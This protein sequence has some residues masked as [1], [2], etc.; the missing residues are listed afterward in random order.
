MSSRIDLT[1]A[2]LDRLEDALEDLELESVPS[3]LAADDPVA[4]RFSEYRELVLLAREAMPLEDVPAGLLDGVIAEAHQAAAAAPVAAAASPSFWSRWRLGTWVPAL[5]FAGSAA[6]L[7]VM[8][9]PRGSEPAGAEVA[10][11]PHG[12]GSKESSK[13]DAK[14]DAS[15][16]DRQLAFAEP[17]RQEEGSFGEREQRAGGLAIGERAP[18]AAPPPLAEPSAAAEAPTDDEAKATEDPLRRKSGTGGKDSPTSEP[19]PAP[20]APASAGGSKGKSEPRPDPLGGVDTGNRDQGED[21]KKADAS[22]LR[23]EIARADADRRGGSCGLAKM[24]YDKLRKADD[25]HVRARAL[26]GA[27]LCAAASD[28]MTTAKKLF[29]QARAADPDV[30]SF[31]DGEL[32]R[33]EGSRTNMADPAPQAAD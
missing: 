18:D 14:A 25:A 9:V 7:L 33:L 27:G 13:A 11:A 23:S 32:A 6:L 30:S 5:A 4:Q 26:A 2:D 3:E 16:A 17:A 19:K 1:P 28:D 21:Q 22:D 29:A 15:A 24:R 12:A 8:L 10:A 20:K 31:I